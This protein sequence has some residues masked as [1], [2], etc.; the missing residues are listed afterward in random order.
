M[1]GKR[2]MGMIIEKKDEEK[3]GDKSPIQ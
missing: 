1:R 3:E 2:E